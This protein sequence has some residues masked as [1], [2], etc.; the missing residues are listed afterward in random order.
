MS[1]PTAQA[2]S[3]GTEVLLTCASV[4]KRRVPPPERITGCAP[5]KITS[6]PRHVLIG[7]RCDTTYR[8]DGSYYP[9][10]V[11]DSESQQVQTGRWRHLVEL[12]VEADSRLVDGLL[13]AGVDF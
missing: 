2:K 5:M 9:L 3:N 1:E 6:E 7:W 8:L 13:S 4:I 10:P 12:V 11:R